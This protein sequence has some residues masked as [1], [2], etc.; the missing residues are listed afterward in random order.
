M[1]LLPRG[2]PT[3][4][5][6]GPSIASKA[7][8][9][10]E[11]YKNLLGDGFK[12]AREAKKSSMGAL[13]GDLEPPKDDSGTYELHRVTPSEYLRGGAPGRGLPRD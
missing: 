11:I 3:L 12:R 10:L 5:P 13:S 2:V 9:V 6:K 7:I 4:A 8:I 1:F